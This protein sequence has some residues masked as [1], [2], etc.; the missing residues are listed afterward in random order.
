MRTSE[1]I[2]KDVTDSLYWDNR[3]DAGEVTVET[4]NGSVTLG[5]TVPSYRARYAAEEDARVVRGVTDVIIQIQVRHPATM[6]VPT[7][8]DIREDIRDSLD[9]DPD[10][11]ASDIEV[12]TGSGWVTLRGSVP[13]LWQKDLVSDVVLS[14]RGVIGFDNELAV[15]PTKTVVDQSIADDIVA[16]LERRITVDPT[17]IDVTVADG[18]VTLTGTVPHWRA[19]N[20]AY[21]AAR[22]T[23]GVI[24]VIDHLTIT[25]A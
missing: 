1:D 19:R 22:Y 23:L 11:D 8:A 4:K 18:Y 16:E 6:T 3:V 10:I 13:S 2:K 9:L 15:V 12:T 21:D 5:G 20:A 25:G 24:D 7:D 17:T 14:T